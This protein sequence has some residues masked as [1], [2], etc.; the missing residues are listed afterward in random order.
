MTLPLEWWRQEMPPKVF[1]NEQFEAFISST[2]SPADDHSPGPSSCAWIIRRLASPDETIDFDAK[3]SHSDK[4][5]EQRGFVAAA[6]G[7][8]ALFEGNCAVSIH[9][10]NQNVVDGLNGGALAWRGNNWKNAQKQP[11]SY[12]E[13]WSLIL[14]LQESRNIKAHGIKVSRKTCPEVQIAHQKALEALARR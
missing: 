6:F 1:G 5:D 7:V 8:I 13:L 12:S 10:N 11:V 3:V 4:S 14:E 2:D 9:T